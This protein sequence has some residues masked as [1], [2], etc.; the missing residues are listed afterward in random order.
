MTRNPE[1]LAL[2]SADPVVGPRFLTCHTLP[3]PPY[4]GSPDEVWLIYGYPPV[5]VG[6]GWYFVLERVHVA[7]RPWP[8]EEPS[9]ARVWRVE[10]GGFVVL[11]PSAN[12]RIM[13][14]EPWD[15][16][17]N[18]RDPY[19][20]ARIVLS[21]SKEAEARAFVDSLGVRA[22]LGRVTAVWDWHEGSEGEIDV[23]RKDEDGR[24]H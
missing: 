20:V 7:D 8:T 4:P 9:S 13:P 24:W 14:P 21:G 17:Q 6:R 23:L 1:D 2:F 5:G 11:V 19:I 10:R 22:F 16:V 18:R 15:P 12:V 3:T